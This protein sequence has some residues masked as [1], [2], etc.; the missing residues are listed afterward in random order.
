MAPATTP[1]PKPTT[2]VASTPAAQPT[3]P[4]TKPTPAAPE[5]KKPAPAADRAADDVQQAVKAWA[6]AWSRRDVDDYVAAYTPSF[7][8]QSGSRKEWVQERRERIAGK[9]SIK[10]AVSD[11]KVSVQG[12]KAT[13]KFRQ[14]Y[15]SDALSTSSRKTLELV[16]SGNKWLIREE[17]VGG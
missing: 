15:T 4:A 5:D 14:S 7:A 13:A 12:D 16:R 3:T 2:T 17:R 11:V 10:V 8:G 6:A 1:A 9:K